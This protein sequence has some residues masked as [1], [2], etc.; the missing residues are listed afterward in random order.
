MQ[1]KRT[2]PEDYNLLGLDAETLR[3]PYALYK[4]LLAGA[5]VFKEPEHGVYL[6]SRYEDIL[7]MKRQPRRFSNRQAT[8][9][10]RMP[11]LDNLPPELVE[12]IKG[13]MN[14]RNAAASSTENYHQVATLL[15]ADPPVH[16]R[17]RGM[18]NKVLNT[19]VAKQWEPRI[20]EIADEL[21]DEFIDQEEIEW[22]TAFAHPLPLRTVGE[23]LGVP[24]GDDA[25][26]DEL[27]GGKNAGDAI[28]NP[29][30]ML[31]RLVDTAKTGRSTRDVYRE[32][33]TDRIQELRKSPV[34]GDFLSE[35]IALPDD[36][37]NPLDDSE[38][39]SIVSHFQVAG[40][41]TSTKMITQA[42]YQLALSSELFDDVRENRQLVGALIE[43]S[44]RYEAPVQGLFQIAEEDVEVGGVPIPK[45]SML[46]TVYA[47]ANR[48][49]RRFENP[50]S[51]NVHRKNVRAHLSFGGGVHSCLGRPFARTEGVQGFHSVFEKIARVQ[52]ATDEADVRRSFSYILRGIPELKLSITPA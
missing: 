46:M 14:E 4:L 32:Y 47:A 8:G 6:V 31:E 2:T 42:M 40:H 44:L 19:R 38:I 39:L 34:A 23:I 48:D 37:G 30:V 5:P 45:G 35:L 36:E 18:T 24:R 17:Y 22:V 7:E 51:F 41:E 9:P 50:D 16:S 27:F 13:L 1:M 26:L 21:I 20:R 43:E 52:L 29:D 49:P 3:D 33:F 10:M 12:K 25:L 11:S 28:G 15:A